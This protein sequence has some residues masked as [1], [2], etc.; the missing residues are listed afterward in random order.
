[1][2][3]MC[4]YRHKQKESKQSVGLGVR[5]FAPP[6][7]LQRGHCPQFHNLLRR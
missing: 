2:W 6:Q 3:E 5:V 1:M 4:A 7:V